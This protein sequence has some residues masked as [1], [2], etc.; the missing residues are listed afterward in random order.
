[1]QLHSAGA[2]PGDLD[3]L[4]LN[5]STLSNGPHQIQ[6]AL[7]DAAGNQALSEPVQVTV[8]NTNPSSPIGVLVDG[9]DAGAWIDQ[10]GTIT[11]TDPSQ[12]Q[13]DPLSQVNWIACTGTETGI[14]AS[15]CDAG[16]HQGSP[17]NSLTFSPAQDAAFAGQPQGIYTVFVWLQDAIGNTAEADSAAISFGYQTSPPPPPTSITASG[18]GPYKITLGAPKDLA[19]LTATSWTACNAVGACTP[20][21]TTPGLSFSFDPN[22]T[23]QFQRSPYGRYTVRAWLRDAAGNASPANSAMLT[24][25]H[26]KPGKPSPQ[27]R[28]LSVTRTGH[29]LRVRGSTSRAVPG[30]VTIAVHY[31]LRARVY[32]VQGTVRVA[33]G[34]WSV[35]LRLPSGA[36][37]DRVTVVRHSSAHWLAQTVTRY[38]HHRPATGR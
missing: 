5:T 37:T 28:I 33:N 29:W 23:P 12:P 25:I 14:P 20:I 10:P 13:D 27:L 35:A 7:V 9:K 2:L 4:S 31:T 17:L 15:G 8:D 34:R 30:P 36:R 38:V 22:G 18:R 21:Q 26:S 32:G 11:W 3:Q 24:I 6:A 16:Q 19:P 1:M